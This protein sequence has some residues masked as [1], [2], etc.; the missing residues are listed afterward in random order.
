MASILE[1]PA[2]RNAA[3]PISVEQYHLLGEAGI[4]GQNIELLH[5]VI[6]EKMV[7]SPE[8]SWLVQRLVDWLR[9]NLPAGW[10]VRQEQPLTFGDSEPEPD[11]AVVEGS[12]DEY[13]LKHPQRAALVIEV[14][15]ASE[16]IDR[17]KALAYAAAGV[18]QYWLVLP[19]SRSIETF[20]APSLRG[21]TQHAIASGADTLA[22]DAIA[23]LELPL[24][25]LFDA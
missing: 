2:V 11:V 25:E 16:A 6:I 10:H 4:I 8:H 7:N 13:R 24:R 20:S 14:A 9:T 21:Y 3:L 17:E 22:V 15:I 5:G 23:Q 1:N 18:G 19:K 12:G